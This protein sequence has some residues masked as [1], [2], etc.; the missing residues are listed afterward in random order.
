MKKNF[1]FTALAIFISFSQLN[2]QTKEDRFS[3]IVTTKLPALDFGKDIM[4]GAGLEYRYNPGDMPEVFSG[5]I[6]YIGSGY[7][8]LEINTG[9]RAYFNPD[10][11][12]F[13]VEA[14][15]IGMLGFLNKSGVAGGFTTGA[16]YRFGDKRKFFVK[17]RANLIYENQTTTVYGFS[18]GMNF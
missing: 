14:G 7:Q 4:F 16:G 8:T 5:A 9:I 11:R 17:F 2:S 18:T 3:A 12:D 6:G 13:F 15:G 10:V 1:I